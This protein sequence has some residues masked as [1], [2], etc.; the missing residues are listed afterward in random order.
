MPPTPHPRRPPRRFVNRWGPVN[1][2]GSALL[3]LLVCA[4]MAGSSPARAAAAPM[5]KWT[6]AAAKLPSG[7]SGEGSRISGLSC[8]GTRLCVASDLDGAVLISGDPFARH[9]AW[10]AVA[11]ERGGQIVGVSCPR[12]T[13][14][15]AVSRDGHAF[16]TS[17]PLGG[18]WVS[19]SLAGA[20]LLATV[21]CSP[22]ATCVATDGAGDVAVTQNPLAGTW[23]V[24]QVDSATRP[25]GKARCQAA[26]TAAACLSGG[27]CLAFDSAGNVLSS[28]TPADPTSWQVV[29][30]D[31]R[32]LRA[33][34]AQPGCG[35]GLCFSVSCPSA[36]SCVAADSNGQ[37][38]VSSD[39]TGPATAWVARPLYAA[40]P[41]TAIACASTATCQLTDAAGEVLAT[42][43]P[44]GGN[45]AF[46]AERVE[47]PA[48]DPGRLPLLTAL[49]CPSRTAC[50]AGDSM[51]R[52]LVGRR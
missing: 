51:G 47:A 48:G 32:G 20:G 40:G 44:A 38:L 1:R 3:V 14:C 21:S 45:A 46:R 23:S 11:L 2:L 22:S 50:L 42:D 26:L 18:A 12:V 7:L 27:A 33:S 29:S 15:V 19:S 52:I 17:H 35:D 24:A 41:V 37:V 34:V 4:G 49:A 9:P 10:K 25:C 30:V 28:A 16:A 5:L 36:G 43:H 8:S 31:R 39:P 13:L 6:P